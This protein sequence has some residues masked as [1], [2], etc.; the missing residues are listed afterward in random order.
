MSSLRRAV[1][2]RGSLVLVATLAVLGGATAGLIHVREEAALDGALNVAAHGGAADGG[3]AVD[4][5]RPPL[6]VRTVERP[7]E[8]DAR[9]RWRD[10]RRSERP[11]FFREGGDR[12]VWVVVERERG[13]GEEHRVVE[14]RAPDVRFLESAGPFL[15]LYVPLAAVAWGIAAGGLA[16]V[17]RRTMAPLDETQHALDRIRGPASGRR[18]PEGGPDEI[19]QVVASVNALLDRLEAAHRAQERFTAEAAHELRTPVTSLRL[20][21]ELARRRERTPEEYRETLAEIDEETTHLQHLVEGLVVLAR[22]DAGQDVP[23]QVLTVD[24]LVRDAV[25][26]EAPAARI[27]VGTERVVAHEELARIALRNL[28]RNAVRHGG[29]DVSVRSRI[30]G[31]CVRIEVDDHGPGVPA[32]DRERVFDTL[33]RGARARTTDPAGLGLGLP[34]ARRIARAEGGDCLLEPGVDGGTRAVLALPHQ[35]DREPASI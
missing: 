33:T 16:V 9:R 34:L 14:A 25:A 24:E 17:V 2:T 18:L 21:V 22:V 26:A 15:A 6:Q 32:E 28:L 20:V 19:R 1:V 3:W 13:G 10:V 29:A 23:P 30:D 12:V 8:D 31:R 35:P 11:V 5:E 27:A 4:H 7:A